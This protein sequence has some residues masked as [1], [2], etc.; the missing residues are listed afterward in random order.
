MSTEYQNLRV[1]L[2]QWEKEF[3]SENGRKPTPEDIKLVAGLPEKY[4]R[5]KVLSKASA[6][7]DAASS[8][9]SGVAAPVSTSIIKHSRAT[10]NERD[11]LPQTAR[12][13]PFSPV[14]KAGQPESL[15]LSRKPSS[16]IPEFPAFPNL[17]ASPKKNKSTTNNTAPSPPTSPN[18]FV[19]HSLAVT[20]SKTVIYSPQ[21]AARKRMRGDEL[22]DPPLPEKKR[23]SM[24]RSSSTSYPGLFGGPS[25]YNLFT[26]DNA[27]GP[28]GLYSAS[29]GGSSAGVSESGDHGQEEVFEPSPVK[30]LIQ[31]GAVYKPIFDDDGDISSTNVASGRLRQGTSR[32]VSMPTTLSLFGKGKTLIK[33]EN[34]T[35][36][37]IFNPRDPGE[38]DGGDMDLGEDSLSKSPRIN[39]QPLLAPTPV[40][41]AEPKQWKGLGKQKKNK[42]YGEQLAADDEE[43]EDG[44]ATGESEMEIMEVGWKVKGPLEP[45]E[46][47]DHPEGFDDDDT[48][49][50]L[51]P[52]QPLKWIRYPQGEAD[53]VQMEQEQLEVDLPDEMR[54]VLQLSS[55]KP[56]VDEEV[57]VQDILSGFGD[58]TRRAEV[59]TAGDRDERDDSEEWDSEGVGWWEAEL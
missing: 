46:A 56:R 50:E 55:S 20:T 3:Q 33:S 51:L 32:T 38:E 28:S 12:P 45:S 15:S 1:E 21:T 41:S 57:L 43:E 9:K 47:K 16:S 6:K 10:E 26:S 34:L 49:L 29:Q 11:A 5:F 59:W 48:N 36:T 35:S 17:F 7:V 31:N 44:G 25:A 30:P 27:S 2:K 14:K 8:S 23:K 18:P 19:V 24:N 22:W 58:R 13:N 37:S 39:S 4:K 52:Q 53:D 42:K 54:E 40:K